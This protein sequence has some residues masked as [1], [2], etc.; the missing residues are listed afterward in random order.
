MLLKEHIWR[1][2]RPRTVPHPRN[3][4]RD[5]IP[6][7]ELTVILGEVIATLDPLDPLSSAG[8]ATCQNQ[9]N[10]YVWAGPP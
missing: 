2:T 6:L 7:E 3:L 4:V 5:S 10:N 1:R 9:P 8:E